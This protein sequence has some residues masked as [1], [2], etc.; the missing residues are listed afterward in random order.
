MVPERLWMLRL[1]LLYTVFYGASILEWSVLFASWIMEVFF[2]RVIRLY[3]T[4]SGCGGSGGF[5][6]FL[7]KAGFSR[8]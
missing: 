4:F 3:S 1:G 7:E 2:N 6:Y 5:S 8:F